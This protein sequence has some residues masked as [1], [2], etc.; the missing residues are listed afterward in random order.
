MHVPGLA[1]PLN[2]GGV[3]GRP[4]WPIWRAGDFFLNFMFF[5]FWRPGLGWPGLAWP[6][7]ARVEKKYIFLKNHFSRFEGP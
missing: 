6:G 4:A 7:L 3:L 2:R 5:S 1:W